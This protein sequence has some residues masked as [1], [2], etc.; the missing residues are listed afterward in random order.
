MAN[1]PDRA[2]CAA[3]KTAADKH[4]NSATEARARTVREYTPAEQRGPEQSD[5]E[6]IGAE[7][8]I[9]EQLS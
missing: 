1:A 7:V 2:V 8:T 4:A 6:D 3:A 9:R 5:A